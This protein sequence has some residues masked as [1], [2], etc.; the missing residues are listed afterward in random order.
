[1]STIGSIWNFIRFWILL[2][3][4]FALNMLIMAMASPNFYAK[5]GFDNPLQI[6]VSIGK[7]LLGMVIIG[8]FIRKSSK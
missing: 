2:G 7:I 5:I 3:L 4:S 1:M 6:G 8:F